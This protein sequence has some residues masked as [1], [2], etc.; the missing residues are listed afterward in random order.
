MSRSDIASI[1]SLLAD[2]T[3]VG[4]LFALLDGRARTGGELAR[5]LGVSAS[6]ISEHVGKLTAAGLTATEAQGRH[7]YVRLADGDVAGLIESFGAATAGLQG[8]ASRRPVGLAHARTCY[9][10]LAGTL[11]VR[12]HDQLLADGALAVEDQQLRL[13]PAGTDRFAALGIDVDALRPS[14][15]PLVRGCLDWTERRKHLAG[16]LGAAMLT[17]LLEAGWIAHGTQPRAIRITR[18]GKR[19][20]PRALGVAANP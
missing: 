8:P 15:R 6:T 17:R 5:H 3:R 16:G 10:H 13:A 9:D 2:D 19:E 11:A 4:L 20:I 14:G 1:A 18:A 7:R 12:I